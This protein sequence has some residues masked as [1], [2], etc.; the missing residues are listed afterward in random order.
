MIS[1]VLK[2]AKWV[3][4]GLAI[5]V[6][7]SF[8]LGFLVKALWNW[9]M[10]EVFGLAAISFWQAWGLLILANLLLGSGARI[11]HDRRRGGDGFRREVKEKLS[12]Q[13]A[14]GDTTPTSA[15]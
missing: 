2:I 5:A 9:L 6:A 14:G 12:P 15:A 11:H 13:A 7:V 8:L 4:L 10:P 1:K 3:V